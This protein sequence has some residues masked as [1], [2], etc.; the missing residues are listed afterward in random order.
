MFWIRSRRIPMTVQHPHPSERRRYPDYL[1]RGWRTQ[2]RHG[3]IHGDRSTFSPMSR[4]RPFVLLRLP[5]ILRDLLRSYN[6]R[7]NIG[8]SSRTDGVSKS[9]VGGKSMVKCRVAQS[10]NGPYFVCFLRFNPGI[11]PSLV[12]TEVIIER[13]NSE[14]HTIYYQFSLL[15]CKEVAM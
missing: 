6:P 7:T 2:S 1:T 10:A 8:F 12:H 11:L 3:S 9:H 5:T 15:R 14:A 4:C 13:R